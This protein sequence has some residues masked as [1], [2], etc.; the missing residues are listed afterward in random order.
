M[1]KIGFIVGSTRPDR[2]AETPTSW[3]IKGASRRSDL[4]LKRLD[5]RYQHLPSFDGPLFLLFIR[6][7]FT[8][9]AAEAW[10]H[11]IGALDGFL[12][13][14]VQYNHGPTAMLKN[15]FVSAYFAWNRRRSP[16]H[17][18]VLR[19]GMIRLP[20]LPPR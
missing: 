9:P 16:A 11:N 7:A 19:K 10:R 17:P 5:L 8:H 1:L 13:T 14:V 18:S 4:T 12:A 15:A 3:M 6:G 20:R 2:F